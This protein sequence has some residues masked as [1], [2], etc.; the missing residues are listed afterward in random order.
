[1]K[2]LRV[3]FSFS[4][5]AIAEVDFACRRLFSNNIDHYAYHYD[6][7]AS[8]DMWQGLQREYS[9]CS[10]II[11]FANARYMDRPYTRREL[12]YF[13]KYQR[14]PGL[15]ARIVAFLNDDLWSNIPD[16]FLGIEC[17]RD[18]EMSEFITDLIRS[19]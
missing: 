1:M 3:G 8:E 14:Q 18:V 12:N 7:I 17:R 5:D 13:S 15:N 19:V 9:R 10:H 6:G 11:V 16:C 2:P 4:G